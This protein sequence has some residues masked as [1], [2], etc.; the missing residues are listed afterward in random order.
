MTCLEGGASP[1]LCWRLLAFPE[2]RG[3][4]KVTRSLSGRPSA[5]K[6]VCAGSAAGLVNALGR[7]RSARLA[8]RRSLCAR[9]CS[10]VGAPFASPLVARQARKR[11]PAPA[12]SPASIGMRTPLPLCGTENLPAFDLTEHATKARAIRNLGHAVGDH[13]DRCPCPDHHCRRLVRDSMSRPGFHAA[14]AR[15][16]AASSLRLR[17]LCREPDPTGL[18]GPASSASVAS[19]QASAWSVSSAGVVQRAGSVRCGRFQQSWR[20]EVSSTGGAM[21]SP[22]LRFPRC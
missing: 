8:S 21:R 2:S 10:R 18:V 13:R 20:R 22:R 14:C 19:S 9:Q 11:R 4:P 6:N 1:A 15:N 16:C 3:A 5:R 12:S 7:T 17:R